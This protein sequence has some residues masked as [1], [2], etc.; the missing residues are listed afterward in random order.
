MFVK[1]WMKTQLVT[2]KPSQTIAEA[3]AI[4][5]QF[6]IRRIPVTDQEGRLVG[7]VT[8]HDI[9]DASPSIIDGSSAGA[10][11]GLSTTTPISTVMT[12]NPI[13]VEPTTPLETVAK[14]MR[15]HKVGGMPVVEDGKLI[16]IITESDIF[17]AFTSVLGAEEEGARIE[18]LVPK[19]AKSFYEVTDICKRYRMNIQ[20]LTIYRDFSDQYQL[21]TIRLSGEELEDMLAALRKSGI[22]INRIIEEHEGGLF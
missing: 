13:S 3:Q 2:V 18:I 11:S 9:A 6:H 10:E 14:R 7:I 4:M 19:T 8:K 16:G 22:K 17:S 15:K 12:V 21:L 1:L 20:A 5:Q